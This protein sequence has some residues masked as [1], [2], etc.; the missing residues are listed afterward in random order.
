MLHKYFVSVTFLQYVNLFFTLF[1]KM[2]KYIII[3]I[4]VFELNKRRNA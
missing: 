4:I 3:D 1:K 2:L